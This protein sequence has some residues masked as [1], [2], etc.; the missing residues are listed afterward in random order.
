MVATLATWLSSLVTWLL[1]LA[2]TTYL[3]LVEPTTKPPLTMFGYP[4]RP[5]TSSGHSNH[6][7]VSTTAG[8]RAA[9]HGIQS[10]GLLRPSPISAWGKLYE[11]L[12]WVISEMWVRWQ[13]GSRPL[14]Y[15]SSR[16]RFNCYVFEPYYHW[17]GFNE[18]VVATSGLNQVVLQNRF[19]GHD[20]CVSK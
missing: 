2:P 4:K 16:A 15:I 17:F 18:R 7:E 20:T 5:C 10:W 12:R 11:Y 6:D 3:G 13:N 1:C 9:D 14:D 8:T 19:G